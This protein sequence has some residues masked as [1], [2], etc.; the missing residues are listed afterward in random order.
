[1]GRASNRKKAHRQA[2]P[3]SRQASQGAR[4]DAETQQA[5]HQLVAGLHALVQETKGRQEREADACRIWSGGAEPV[6]AEAARWS[7][8]SLGDR[9]AH[10]G[11]ELLRAPQDHGPIV[12][13]RR[14]R[15]VI[16]S[17]P[18]PETSPKADGPIDPTAG[19]LVGYCGMGRER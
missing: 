7:E 8:G 12:R 15:R 4:A 5:M 14:S 3:S 11:Q 17:P 6:P 18:V 2:G 16:A 9:H 19:G 13:R 1:M 10:D